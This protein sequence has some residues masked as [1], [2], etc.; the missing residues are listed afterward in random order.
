[1]TNWRVA[2]SLLILRT[3]VNA[4][5]VRRS[6]ASDGTI[7][8]PAHAARE[9]DHNP[10]GAHVV[11]AMD[12]TNDPAH[13]ADMSKLAGFLLHNPHPALKYV[14]WNRRIASRTHGWSWLPY[15]GTNPHTHHVHISVGPTAAG[16][17][18]RLPWGAALAWRAPTRIRP[19]TKHPD[20][21]YLQR[22][23]GVR[24]TNLADEVTIGA[25]RR[26]QSAHHLDA[27]GVAGP[28]TWGALL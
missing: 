28:K 20:V 1:M 18:C 17:D 15:H 14:I 22:V 9:S 8:D 25:L 23:L 21:G 3:E 26:Y 6:T 5:A 19:G 10:N 27:D 12:L 7:G 13:G 16:Y 24:V 11:C 4:A 2:A